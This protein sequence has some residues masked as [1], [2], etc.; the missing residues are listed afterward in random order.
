[1]SQ[2]QPSGRL[3]NPHSPGDVGDYM[4]THG[5]ALL[6]L[7]CAYGEED[8]KERRKELREILTRAVQFTRDAQTKHVLPRDPKTKLGGW[9]YVSAKEGNN[10]DVCPVAVTQM[11]GLRAAQNAGIKTSKDALQ[12]AQAYLVASTSTDGGVVFSLGQGAGGN[13]QWTVTSGALVGALSAGDKDPTRMRNWLRFVEKYYQ[14]LDGGYS[15]YAHYYYSQAL[16]HLGDDGYA[17]LMKDVAPKDRKNWSW[18]KKENFPKFLKSQTKEGGWDIGN[19]GPI[20]STSI[21]LAIL[22]LENSALPLYQRQQFPPH[23]PGDR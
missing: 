22:Q 17:K 2:A 4:Y 8:D 7:S 6:F 19:W 18:Y 3:G 16:Y 23:G 15:A 11:Q 14:P 9:G 13:G 12:V 21:I 1:M 5:Y 10:F 20:Y